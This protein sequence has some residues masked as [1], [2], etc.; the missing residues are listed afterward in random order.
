[1]LLRFYLTNGASSGKCHVVIIPQ[2]IQYMTNLFAKLSKPSDYIRLLI[3]SV[4]YGGFAI[5]SRTFQ[6]GGPITKKGQ[7]F[8]NTSYELKI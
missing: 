8:S 7:P 6:E 4:I 1:M 3:L 5:T 2:G